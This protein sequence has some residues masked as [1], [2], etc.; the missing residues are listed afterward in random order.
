MSINVDHP[1]RV[2]SSNGNI[3][4]KTTGGT[5]SVP[6]PVIIDADYLRLPVAITP[7]ANFVGGI[8]MDNRNRR[9]KYNNGTSWITIPTYEEIVDPLTVRIDNIYSIL[10]TKIDKV[11]YQESNVPTAS[12]SGTTLNIVF[13]SDIG[14]NVTGANGLYT[15]LPTG[16]ITA[17]SL[18]SGQNYSSVRAQLGNQTGRSGTQ[19]SPYVTST[20]WVIADGKYWSWV[21]ESGTKTVKVPNLNTNAY[22][23][24]I[25]ENGV[26]K[27]DTVI[28]FT[29][30][31]TGG[32]TLTIEQSAPHQH[33]TPG[34]HGEDGDY[35]G[36]Y[37]SGTDIA[38]KSIIGV[39][40][41]TGVLTSKTTSTG[42]GEPHD[43]TLP[44]IEPN[45]FNIV[46]LYNIAEPE[47]AISSSM[48]DSLYVKLAG[49]EMHGDLI[50]HTSD[51]PATERSAVSYKF[52]TDS[53]N[54]KLSLSGGTIT[55]QVFAPT[56]AASSTK[57]LVN[58]EYVNARVAA[59]DMSGYLPLTGGTMN[60]FIVHQV[61]PNVVSNDYALVNKKYI[62][63]VLT[64]YLPLSGGTLS[65]DLKLFTT[66]LPS[67]L[68]SAVSY[69]YLVDSLENKLSLAGGAITGPVTV[70]TP[71]STSAKQIANVEYVNSKL[72][73]TTMLDHIKATSVTATIMGATNIAVDN[74]CILTYYNQE[75]YGSMNVYDIAK[76]FGINGIKLATKNP[77]NT[78]TNYSIEKDTT[79]GTSVSFQF[80]NGVY[81]Y[82]N[83]GTMINR[84]KAKYI[85][86]EIIYKIGIITSSVLMKDADMSLTLKF[87]Y[88]S[89]PLNYFKT[90]NLP[91]YS[92]DGTYGIKPGDGVTH[93]LDGVIVTC[94]YWGRELSSGEKAP[95]N[96]GTCGPLFDS[97]Y[98][99]V[100]NLNHAIP[101]SGATEY[102]M[103]LTVVVNHLND[104]KGHKLYHGFECDCNVDNSK[105][106]TSNNA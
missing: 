2:I 75:N 97:G 24:G 48:A 39:E 41:G 90:I 46:W 33:L 65:G 92:Q 77:T 73:G 53:L 49:D 45:H 6:S 3:T 28:P 76:T 23:K 105:P 12:I 29:G 71:S 43:H 7:V 31:K 89:S 84:Y 55:G 72:S 4:M 91:S 15:S 86:A 8:V 60:G 32:T 66:G 80:I 19:S 95:C 74:V 104:P 25:S 18:V 102:G 57:Q 44:E 93:V 47:T 36:Q 96:T 101:Y 50:L 1:K 14:N 58:V 35:V 67:S 38:T 13:P 54:T 59:V 61:E 81:P 52:L 85:D 99:L 69:K 82:N 9:L 68:N 106:P 26:T 5:S 42:G 17:Y 56:P 78:K 51:T 64:G 40:L 21:T 103:I 88:A 83:S 27:T 34:A 22:L 62:N 11:T 30:G 87:S 94:S 63:S 37:M 10:G 98:K 16:S 79:V 70:P 100:I 20:G